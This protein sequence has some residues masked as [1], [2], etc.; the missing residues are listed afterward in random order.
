[1][2]APAQIAMLF[3]DAERRP[4]RIGRTAVTY[5]AGRV[6]AKASGFISAYD[7]VLNPYGG[8]S[9]RRGYCYARAFTPTLEQRE[10]WGEWL[11][12]RQDAARQLRAAAASRSDAS[13]LEPGDSVYMSTVTDPYQPIEKQALVSRAALEV[14][15]EVQPRLTIQ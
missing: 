6:L 3:E 15:A 2:T 13:R 12:V 7:W 9:F 14:L 11:K 4:E 8:C 5:G 1:M 10:R